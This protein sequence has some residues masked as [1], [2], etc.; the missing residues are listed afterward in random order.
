[1]RAS[2]IILIIVFFLISVDLEGFG[3]RRAPG[4]PLGDPWRAPGGPLE[5]PWRPPGEPLEAPWRH[6]GGSLEG[7]LE[8]VVFIDFRLLLLIFIDLFFSL[9][10]FCAVFVAVF[11]SA[12]FCRRWWGT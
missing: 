1:M 4:R 6:P 12:V 5:G 9:H 8:A 11:V 7:P 10:V 2:E 3:R